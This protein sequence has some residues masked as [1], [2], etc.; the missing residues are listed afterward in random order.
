MTL[1]LATMLWCKSQQ[2]CHDANISNNNMKLMLATVEWCQGQ[3]WMH[4]EVHDADTVNDI[5]IPI[6]ILYHLETPILSEGK[7]ISCW[8]VVD[9]KPVQLALGLV[10]MVTGISLLDWGLPWYCFSFMLFY[11]HFKI[12]TWVLWHLLTK[13]GMVGYFCFSWKK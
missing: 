6:P 2:W 13:L 5:V 7:V 10:K 1:I 12:I 4:V 3:Q 9:V 8:F 11:F